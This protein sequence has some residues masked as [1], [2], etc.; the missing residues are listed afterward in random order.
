MDWALALVSDTLGK[1]EAVMTLEPS[2]I[3][4]RNSEPR[5]G[6]SA[7]EAT[8]AAT[9]PPKSQPPCERDQSSERA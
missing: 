9:E 2:S 4:G 7:T 6:T 8:R 5:L 3:W 1:R